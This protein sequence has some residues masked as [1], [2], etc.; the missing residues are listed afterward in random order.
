MVSDRRSQ[1]FICH[2]SK[3]KEDVVRIAGALE[4][5]TITV[6]YDDW[7]IEFGDTIAANIDQ[8]ISTSDYV[9]VVLT[10]NSVE[11]RWVEREWSAAYYEEQKWGAVKVLPLLLRDCDVPP[12][13][14]DKK[15]VDLR[16][17]LFQ[18]NLR[19]LAGWI[20]SK[21]RGGN[22]ECYQTP[23]GSRSQAIKGSSRRRGSR[24]RPVVS[25]AH[26]DVRGSWGSNEEAARIADEVAGIVAAKALSAYPVALIDHLDHGTSF[27]SGQVVAEVGRGRALIDLT[28]HQG[29]EV[30]FPELVSAIGRSMEYFE[31]RFPH[32]MPVTTV[33]QN[34]QRKRLEPTYFRGQT[35]R[36]DMTNGKLQVQADAEGLAIRWMDDRSSRLADVRNPKVLLD[37]VTTDMSVPDFEGHF[38]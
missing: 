7:S 38:E 26:Y 37:F 1:V 16:G 24:D 4:S 21:R 3:D 28:V 25:L 15:Y 14:A 34:L 9:A 36:F 17:P 27:P 30:Q 33:L 20:E 35:L 12:L 10:P 5:D 2:S 22:T 19:K 18:P 31:F 8:G 29:C 11:S 13:L 32:Q 23:Q 6:W